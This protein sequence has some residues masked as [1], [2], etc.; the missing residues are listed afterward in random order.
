MAFL[1][2]IWICV[3][4]SRKGKCYTRSY[5]YLHLSAV[6]N[7]S[8]PF[9]IQHFIKI[10]H[11]RSTAVLG[12]SALEHVLFSPAYSALD[13]DRLARF[14][15]HP[16]VVLSMGFFII[17]S[18]PWI[19]SADRLQPGM[20][21]KLVVPDAPSKIIRVGETLERDAVI[22]MWD[23][24]YPKGSC[25][26]G[27]PASTILLSPDVCFTNIGFRSSDIHIRQDAVCPDGKIPTFVTFPNSGCVE[28]ANQ[29]ELLPPPPLMGRCIHMESK[30]PFRWSMIF[31]CAEE[32]NSA[33]NDQN[34]STSKDDDDTTSAVP[35]STMVH[36]STTKGSFNTRTTQKTFKT[37]T[38]HRLNTPITILPTQCKDDASPYLFTYVRRDCQGKPVSHGILE[39]PKV[40]NPVEKLPFSL[41]LSCDTEGEDLLSDLTFWISI[42]PALMGTIFH[43]GSQFRFHRIAVAFWVFVCCLPLQKLKLERFLMAVVY[44]AGARYG[45]YY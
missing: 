40:W 43:L 9:S 41:V 4:V 1:R 22:R 7:L 32:E 3:P 44:F 2:L 8:L 11:L 12:L 6:C 25:H 17:V 28:S 30:E 36:S 34:T 27:T 26:S 29:T 16:A 24:P 42:I 21:A 38:C 15:D 13:M 5:I 33:Q 14:F 18:S 35:N 19:L 31:K 20:R 10:I 45:P 23:E 37:D 39:Y